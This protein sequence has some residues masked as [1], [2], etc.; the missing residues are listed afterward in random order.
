MTT[1][2]IT[3]ANRGIGLELARQLTADG[4]TVIGTARNPDAATELT[5]TG[6]RVERLDVADPASVRALGERLAGEPIDVLIN[7]A[8]IFNDKA[9]GSFL[10]VKPDQLEETYRVNAIGPVLVTQALLPNVEQSDGK[11]VVHISSDYGSHDTASRS[12]WEGNLA[13]RSSKSAL[14]MNHVLMSNELA[15][16]GVTSLAI[17]PGWVETDMGGEGAALSPE[18][19]VTAIRAIVERASASDNGKFFSYEG[20]EMAW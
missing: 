18:Q 6:A 8:G 13:Y 16:R 1:Y 7:N 4:H 12:E 10:E 5:Q 2:C 9:A 3:G 19:S 11:L 17:H 20:H 14:N 15:K